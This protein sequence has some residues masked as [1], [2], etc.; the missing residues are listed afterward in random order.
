[1]DDAKLFLHSN[2]VW[3]SY[4]RHDPKNRGRQLLSKLELKYKDE[5]LWASIK[6]PTI[7]VCCGRNM[8]AFESTAGPGSF[9]DDGKKNETLQLVAWLDPLVVG[10]VNT[11]QQV[12]D[13]GEDRQHLLDPPNSKNGTALLRLHG[14]TGSLVLA[15]KL[16]EYVGIGHYHRDDD[17]STGNRDVS[18]GSLYGHHYT[19]VFFTVSTDPPFRMKQISNEFVLESFGH[20]GDADIVQFA[21]G[22]EFVSSN[23][24]DGLD[25]FLIAYGIN[26]CEAATAS[27]PAETVYSMLQPLP[28]GGS[29]HQMLKPI[30]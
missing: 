1:M 23:G 4:T 21:S 30:F 19:H 11:N 22:L 24:N 15:P 17:S 3:I 8:A 18:K 29:I 20:K 9:D 16:N 26:D 13:G 25:A 10:S 12:M 2:S 14:T 28:S 6:G 7:S 27:V 5:R